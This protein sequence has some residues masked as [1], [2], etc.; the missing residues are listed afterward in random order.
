[1]KTQ[2]K[3]MKTRKQHYDKLWLWGR[4]LNL[5][6]ATVA[7]EVGKYTY[8]DSAMRVNQETKYSGEV[9]SDEVQLWT[10]NRWPEWT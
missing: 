8:K 7:W 9:I 2:N 6:L 10:E 3:A 5:I 4:N 1:M